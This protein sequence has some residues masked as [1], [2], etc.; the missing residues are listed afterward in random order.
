MCN[1]GTIRIYTNASNGINNSGKHNTT[2]KNGIHIHCVKNVR[3]Q[4]KT[5]REII[6]KATED[7]E[8]E[9][10]KDKRK[11]SVILEVSFSWHDNYREKFW[12]MF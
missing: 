1:L 7:E 5:I 3:E 8:W 11:P 4:Y 10:T 2:G 12:H 6:D 9:P